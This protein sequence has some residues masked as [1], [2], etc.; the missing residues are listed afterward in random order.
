MGHVQ[1]G[2]ACVGS[3]RAL[4]D[5]RMSSGKTANVTAA[6]RRPV[7]PF[8]ALIGMLLAAFHFGANRAALISGRPPGEKE[9]PGTASSHRIPARLWQDPLAA[10]GSDDQ[11]EPIFQFKSYK[12][13]YRRITP[14]PLLILSV[15]LSSAPYGEIVE[16]RLRTRYAVL[17]ALSD[18]GYTPADHQYLAFFCP[19][20]QRPAR[21]PFEW[22]LYEPPGGGSGPGVPAAA[23][24]RPPAAGPGALDR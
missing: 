5:W 19:V 7:G 22:H 16:N 14:A 20:T 4:L 11:M 21:V 13:R 9:T 23:A 6:G 12:R 1:A 17:A 3:G 2:G 8:L 15:F 18:A 24:E 10:V